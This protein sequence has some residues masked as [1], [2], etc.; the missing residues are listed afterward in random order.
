MNGSIAYQGEP[1]ANS[2]AACTD[3]FPGHRQLPCTTFSD[4]LDA[5]NSGNADLAMIPVDNS[6]AGRVA[7]IHHLLP[8]SGLHIVGEYF[9]PIHFHLMA[10]PG[11]DLTSI[12]TVRSHVHALGQCRK[13]IREHGWA[14][15]VSDDTA[16]AAREVAE[17]ADPAEA[18][19]SPY[20]AAALYGLNILAPDVED[21][22]HNTTRFLVLSGNPETPLPG[23]GPVITSYL[24][25][26]RNIPSSLY[27]AIGGFASNGVNMTKIESYQLGGSFFA[28]QFY[29]DIEGHPEDPSVALALEELTFFSAEVRQLG[30][31]PAH[32]YRAR[33]AEPQPPEPR[34]RH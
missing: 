32:P 14:T 6:T 10:V 27:K 8:E 19:L 3:M 11:A 2:A 20:A 15:A 30:V 18:A 17:L 12:R 16:G 7:D 31:Y 34:P 1:G 28:S 23:S 9:L 21:E 26:V 22:H 29:V 13:I 5:V 25:R 33:I 4:A 24:F